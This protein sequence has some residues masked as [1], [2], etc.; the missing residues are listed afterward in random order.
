M[1]ASKY[2][3][4]QLKAL[5]FIYCVDTL[6]CKKEY[7]TSHV[8][9]KKNSVKTL[10]LRISTPMY[11]FLF[12]YSICILSNNVAKISEKNEGEAGRIG[13]RKGKREERMERNR[14]RED[15]I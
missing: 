12:F 11:G 15:L 1:E 10:C 6:F 5:I 9:Y 7:L 4:L 14:G 3:K 2:N 8:I 13:E